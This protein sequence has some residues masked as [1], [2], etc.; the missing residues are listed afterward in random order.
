MSKFGDWIRKKTNKTKEALK[1]AGTSIKWAPLL[2]FKSTLKKILIK[3]GVKPYDK[4]AQLGPQFYDIVIRKRKHVRSFEHDID[5]VTITLIV[6]TII[7]FIKSSI[8][9][10]E[11]EEKLKTEE[12]D[13]AK[14][15][16][17]A[18]KTLKKQFNKEQEKIVRRINLATTTSTET[19][20]PQAAGFGAGLEGK[21]GMILAGVAL[22]FIFLSNRK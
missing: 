2:P 17:E 12:A 21:Q 8:K 16:E 18:V 10:K 9:K 6:T 11:N 5:P 22:L 15:A 1:K 7:N 3:K 4:M 19:T 13:A 14:G 20:P